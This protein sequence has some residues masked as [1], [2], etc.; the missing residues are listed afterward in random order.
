MFMHVNMHTCISL[1]ILTY[2]PVAKWRLL[3]RHSV[4]ASVRPL[5]HGAPSLELPP[6]LCKCID[7]NKCSD[8][9]YMSVE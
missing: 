8:I 3:S 6:D 7:V 2:V 5:G 1:R 4:A 9:V